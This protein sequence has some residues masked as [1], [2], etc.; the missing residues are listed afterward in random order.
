MKNF[1]SRLIIGASELQRWG[2]DALTKTYFALGVGALIVTVASAASLTTTPNHMAPQDISTL[3]SQLVVGAT[4]MTLNPIKRW[5]NGVKVSGCFKT[6]SGFLLV[7]D[8]LGRTEFMSFNGNACSATYVTTLSNL[9]RGLSATGATFTAG[10]G[11][12]FDAGAS[13][14]LT[15]YPI[16]YNYALYKDL[17]NT[18]TGSGQLTSDETHQAFIN[19]NCITTTQRD[20]FTKVTNGDFICNSSTGTFQMRLG[21]AWS[22]VGTATVANASDTV[23]G[24]LQTVTLAHLQ[25]RT[26]TGATGAINAL[27]PRWVL[28]NATGSVSFGRIPQLNQN[29][30]LDSSFFQRTSSGILVTKTGTGLSILRATSSG[31]TLVSTATNSWTVMPFPGAILKRTVGIDKIATST[32]DQNFANTVVFPANSLLTGSVVLFNITGS[33]YNAGSSV[34]DHGLK[35]GSTE[36]CRSDKWSYAAANEKRWA[37]RAT[38]TVQSNGATGKIQTDCVINEPGNDSNG[39][40]ASTSS[41]STT[42]IN[43]TTPNTVNV[44]NG[45][46]QGTGWAWITQLFAQFY[47]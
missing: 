31:Q 3:R 8:Y 26:D 38:M 32:G 28:R 12:A 30:V 40:F 34:V 33:G 7:Q 39:K 1:F 14:K 6:G 5:Q 2:I 16:I 10:T 47:Q 43:T 22:D 9:R 45:N 11:L 20:A 36:L 19:Y 41:G 23:S 13:V 4:S 24:K 44:F 21:G 42:T 37:I 29:G 15:D 18:I 25:Q 17:V 35:L 46:V 27:T